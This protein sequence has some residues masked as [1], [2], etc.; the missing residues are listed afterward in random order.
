VLGRTRKSYVGPV[1]FICI[2]AV[3]ALLSVAQH[4]RLFHAEGPLEAT[5]NII[6]RR[7]SDLDDIARFLE[8]QGI[9][10]NQNQFKLGVRMRGNA[11]SLRA[12][13]FAIPRRASAK[14]VMDVL[15]SGQPV[16]RRVQA[17]EGLTSSEFME[18]FENS[19]ALIADHKEVPANGT[20]MPDTY[21]YTYGD[22][23]SKIIQQ[24]KLEMDR[25]IRTAWENR[26]PGL[27]FKNKEEAM[28]LA[29]IVE[30]ETHIPA[31]RPL[32]ASVFINRLGRRMRLQSDPTVIFALSGRSKM[33]RALTYDDLKRVDRFNTYTV[34][35]LPPAPICNPS[36]SAI[37]AV[38]QPAS[39]DYL[40][41]VAGKDGAHV[42]A[43]TY[44]EHLKNVQKWRRIQQQRRRNRQ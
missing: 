6:I 15:V 32:V 8:Q 35:G 13:E 28:V 27:P 4:V 43:E 23:S 44:N 2:A 29:S 39:S 16:L 20:L 5:T 26:A 7:G 33:D 11:R 36:R 18:L 34:S 31:E 30:R 3:I 22:R 38:L 17:T 19:E 37:D 9:I 10:N 24:M 40:Y 12:G 42:F 41:F 1:T 21:H 25:Y 14:M